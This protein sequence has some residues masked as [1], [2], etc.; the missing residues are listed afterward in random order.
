MNKLITTSLFVTMLLILSSCGSAANNVSDNTEQASKET[1]TSDSKSEEKTVIDPFENV[2]YTIPDSEDWNASIYPED[3]KIYFD[4][5]ESP[6]GEVATFTFFIE[7]ADDEEIIIRSR[8]NIDTEEVQEYL[9]ENN[10][11]VDENEK[12]FEIKVEDLETNLLSADN[13]DETSYDKLN[14]DMIDYLESEH[15]TAEE[16]EN[17]KLSFT[18]EKLYIFTPKEIEYDLNNQKVESSISRSLDDSSFEDKE[19]ITNEA[20]LYIDSSNVNRCSGLGIYSDN[21]GSYYCIE[22]TPIKF[23]KKVMEDCTFKLLCNTTPSLRLSYEF[24]N[25]EEVYDRFFEWEYG[26][27]ESV[28]NAVDI[29]H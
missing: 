26:E 27:G 17:L 15:G 7:S 4:A 20:R 6:I 25:E 29:T 8:A 10:L 23:N 9:E 16:D 13:I 3:F 12:T 19:I 18:L 24:Q 28:I 5:S 11:K 21:N 1:S 22:I 2:S 14:A